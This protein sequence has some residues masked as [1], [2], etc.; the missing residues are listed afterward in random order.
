ME[1]KLL[2]AVAGLDRII[3]DLSNSLKKY[4]QKKGASELYVQKQNEL[5]RD[6]IC[7]YNQLSELKF[8]QLWVEIETRIKNLEEQ[9]PEL[10]AHTI[11]IHTRPG[12]QHNYSFIEI[13][14][15]QS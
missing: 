5:I 8:L 14:P 3:A 4:V 12:N 1:T 13:N 15:F 7:L 6:L 10:N 2:T 11:I 9:D